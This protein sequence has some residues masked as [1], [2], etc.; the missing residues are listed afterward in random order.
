MALPIKTSPEDV[1]AIITFLKSKV[2]GATLAEAKA[3][4]SPTLLD[5]RKLA[6]YEAWGFISRVDDRLA[7]TEAGRELSRA[8]DNEAR[9]LFAHS[10]RGIPAYMLILEWM[11]HQGLEQAT[12]VE[13]ASHWHTHSPEALGTSSDRTM[14]DQ[15]VCFFSLAQ[16]AGLGNRIVGRKGQPTR[17]EVDREV[18]SHFFSEDAHKNVALVS[19]ESQV[20][21]NGVDEP[22]ISSVNLLVE[23]HSNEYELAEPSE[24]ALP[25]NVKRNQRVFITHGSNHEVVR[26][27]KELLTFGK[28]VPVVAE[29][30]ETP[31]KPVP[32]KVLE[33]MRACS[34]AVIH[35]ESE[36]D[37]LDS[38]G[39]VV[40]KLNDNVL[41]EI[42]AAMALYGR[43]FI[44]LVQDGVHLPSNLQG[45]YRCDYHGEKLDYDATMKLLKAFNEFS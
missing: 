37:L 28:F 33:D 24:E 26:Q 4:L 41:I 30:H 36:C 45:L 39:N 25:A 19:A 1:Q 2:S 21:A 23:P 15:A 22:S 16:A 14:V 10:I 18:L 17:L 11:F 3:V 44:L 42:G 9:R 43:N 20:A 27:L 40:R 13:V 29:E 5:G 34:A 38:E 32:D 31:S 12:S 6:A 8:D 7:L 35:V